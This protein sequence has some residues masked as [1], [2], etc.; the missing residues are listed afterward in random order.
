[1][2][3]EIRLWLTIKISIVEAKM[4]QIIY[5]DQY[6]LGVVKPPGMPVQKDRSRDEDLVTTSKIYL[7]DALDNKGPIETIYLEVINRL[8]RPVGGIVILA[9]DQLTNQNLSRQIHSRQMK[10]SYLAIINGKPHAKE[11]RFVDYLTKSIKGVAAVVKPSQ[12][13]AKKAILSYKNICGLQMNSEQVTL[14]EI[15]LETGRFHQIRVQLAHH[16]LPIVGDT[17]Y[18]PAYQNKEGW[19]QIQLFAYGY[20]F[21]HPFSGKTIILKACPDYF[22]EAFQ[23]KCTELDL[24]LKPEEMG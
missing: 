7:S 5:E 10:K 20:V 4:V 11:D 8:D 19:H 3:R 14:L 15:E 17:K 12:S 23:K 24:A 2:F 13:G 6:I 21:K 9:K 22:I 1:M 16:N 18:N